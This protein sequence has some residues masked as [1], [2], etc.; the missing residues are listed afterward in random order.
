MVVVSTAKVVHLVDRYG[1][2]S[3]SAHTQDEMDI[4]VNDGYLV[5]MTRHCST[6]GFIHV[7]QSLL[8]KQHVSLGNAGSDSTAESDSPQSGM[9]DPHDPSGV[10]ISSSTNDEYLCIKP[11]LAKL[12]V[13]LGYF[14]VHRLP[15]EG[16]KLS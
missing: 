14:S 3:R 2:G 4:Y 11:T 9:S 8:Q 13:S 7:T 12:L 10:S 15:L 16:K 6:T 1:D 5:N